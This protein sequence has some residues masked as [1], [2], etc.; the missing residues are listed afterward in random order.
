MGVQ[1]VE[2]TAIRTVPTPATSKEG[3]Q[4]LLAFPVEYGN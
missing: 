3:R 4:A 1:R 2:L